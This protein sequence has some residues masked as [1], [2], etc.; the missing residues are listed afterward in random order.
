[1][2]KKLKNNEDWISQFK[3]YK[4]ELYNTQ[5]TADGKHC[6]NPTIVFEVKKEMDHKDFFIWRGF[7]FSFLEEIEPKYNWG[8]CRS[9]QHTKSFGNFFEIHPSI[10]EEHSLKGLLTESQLRSMEICQ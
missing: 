6:V 10:K 2:L 9:N 7:L 4:Y 8:I 3:D 5:Y 1:M